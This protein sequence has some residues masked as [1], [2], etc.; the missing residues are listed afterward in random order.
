M[1]RRF[2]KSVIA[3]D[4]DEGIR[5]SGVIRN[6]ENSPR[7]VA[8]MNSGLVIECLFRLQES[9]AGTTLSSE[10]SPPRDNGVT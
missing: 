4:I 10:L 8:A 9:Q 5:D 6:S 7:A 2:A 1:S 3:S